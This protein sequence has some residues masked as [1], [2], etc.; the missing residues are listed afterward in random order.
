MFWYSV[1]LTLPHDV[2]LKGQIQDVKRK[3]IINGSYCRVTNTGMS[4][5]TINVGTIAELS[6]T[7]A[8]WENGGT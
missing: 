8:R 1:N 7:A 6:D 2:I 4:T 3:Q 5:I